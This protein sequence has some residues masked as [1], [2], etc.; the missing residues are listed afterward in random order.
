M[1]A[2]CG[3]L[4]TITEVEGTIG[5]S[6]VLGSCPLDKGTILRV[7]DALSTTT[8]GKTVTFK[9]TAV[10]AAFE[11]SK[12]AKDGST[13]PEWLALKAT[14]QTVDENGDVV[15]GWNIGLA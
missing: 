9:K 2:S 14:R 3:A 12:G 15:S 1:F 8:T 7:Y 5:T 11:T 4:K 6:I 10:D 13:S